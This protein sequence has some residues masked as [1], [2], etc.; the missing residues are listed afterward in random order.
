ML[1]NNLALIGVMDQMSWI[2]CHGSN[3]VFIFGALCRAAVSVKL[4]VSLLR[5][6]NKQVRQKPF[7][8]TKSLLSS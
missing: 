5:S 3:A 2:K 1:L 4:A 8:Q 6:G 7:L